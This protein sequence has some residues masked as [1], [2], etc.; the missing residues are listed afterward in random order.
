MAGFS[1][2]LKALGYTAG[3]VSGGPSQVKAVAGVVAVKGKID[4]YL[5][6]FG[7]SVGSVLGADI[8]N[9]IGAG[10]AVTADKETKS[11]V[12]QKVLT[13]Q[14][15]YTFSLAVAGVLAIV[16]YYFYRGKK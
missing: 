12:D 10:A 11:F 14:A 8:F 6:Q 13:P 4:D 9:K 2:V 1:D 3:A 16:A 7:K 15:K 5:H